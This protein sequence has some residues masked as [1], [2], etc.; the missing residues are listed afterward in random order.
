MKVRARLS[1]PGVRAPGPGASGT[2]PRMI[3]RIA[4]ARGVMVMATYN[5]RRVRLAPHALY[6]RHGEPFLDAVT[7]EQDGWPPNSRRL[8]AFKLDGL[9]G[10]TATTTRFRAEAE[11]DPDND[12]YSG[13]LIAMIGFA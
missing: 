6:T 10:I 13:S 5:R 9:T 12:K 1:L 7:V 2:D 8:G 3:L 4:V 11:F